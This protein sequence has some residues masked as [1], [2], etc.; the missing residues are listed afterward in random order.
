VDLEITE[1]S[2]L[3]YNLRNIPNGRNAKSL[4]TVRR[5]INSKH[6]ATNNNIVMANKNL[7]V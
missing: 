7:N 4:A 3:V 1:Y 2:Q 5:S 6:C